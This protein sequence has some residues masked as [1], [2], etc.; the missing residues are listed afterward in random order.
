[1]SLVSLQFTA[2]QIVPALELVQPV[3]RKLTHYK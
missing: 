2:A 3:S 1:M